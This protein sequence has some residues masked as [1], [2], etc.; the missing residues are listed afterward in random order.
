MVLIAVARK[1][2]SRSCLWLVA[3]LCL[4]LFAATSLDAAL[5]ISATSTVA[6]PGSTGNAIEITL[7]NASGVDLDIGAFSFSLTVTDADVEFTSVTT[8]TTGAPYVFAGSSGVGSPINTIPPPVGQMV[9]ASDYTLSSGVTVPAG[10]TV[11]L[12]HVLFDVLSAA[13]PT[14]VDV[15]FIGYPATSVTDALSGLDIPISEFQDGQITIQEGSQPVPEPTALAVWSLI[16]ALG[17][18]FAWY[19]RKRGG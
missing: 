14:V 6:S 15:T 16:A 1:V 8:D 19:R 9:L 2:S 10:A 7:V 4:P 17:I 13:S 11:G 3:A 5:I 12:G 18:A